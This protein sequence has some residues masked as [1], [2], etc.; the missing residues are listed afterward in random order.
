[1]LPGAAT[2]AAVGAAHGTTLTL[3]SV[4]H[5]SCFG[6]VPPAVLPPHADRTSSCGA[7]RQLCVVPGFAYLAMAVWLWYSLRPTRTSEVWRMAK[8]A[9][10]FLTASGGRPDSNHGLTAMA[11]DGRGVQAWGYYVTRAAEAATAA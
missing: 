8:R 5:T 7:M 6:F 4:P 1:M 9:A 10:D 3:G 11:Q 2:T